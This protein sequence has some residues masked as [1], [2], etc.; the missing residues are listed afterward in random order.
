MDNDYTD[1]FALSETVD[2]PCD[3]RD[4]SE[5]EFNIDC[6]KWKEF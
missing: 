1:I 6:D 4:C 3:E 2:D 5:C